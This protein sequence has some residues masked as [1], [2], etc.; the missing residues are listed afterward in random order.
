VRELRREAEALMDAVELELVRAAR[1]R[2][3]PVTWERIGKAL[4]VSHTQAQRRF[5]D[6]L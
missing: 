2:P 5:K 4:G 6:R 3:T 1:S